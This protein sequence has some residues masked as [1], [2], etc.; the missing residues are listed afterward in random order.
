MLVPNSRDRHEK[1]GDRI[2]H[3]TKHTQVGI[4]RLGRQ[5]SLQV[6]MHRRLGIGIV[7]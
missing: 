3:T 7:D 5:R 1:N 6:D 2:L 4:I